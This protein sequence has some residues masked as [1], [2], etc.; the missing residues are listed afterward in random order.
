MSQ[1]SAEVSIQAS[2]I[3]QCAEKAVVL[4]IL[5][6]REYWKATDEPWDTVVRV[7]CSTVY[8][9]LRNMGPGDTVVRVY[10]STVYSSLRNIA[11]RSVSACA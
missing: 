7:Y 8:R 11:S 5:H 2:A 4:R 1:N 6:P 3:D 10:S 9:S